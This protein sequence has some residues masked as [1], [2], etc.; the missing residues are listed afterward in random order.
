[1]EKG[2]QHYRNKGKLRV[3]KQG[4]CSTLQ[5]QTYSLT[6]VFFFLCQVFLVWALA[7]SGEITQLS[8]E[9]SFLDFKL[10]QFLSCH[11]FRVW[12]DCRI[13]VYMTP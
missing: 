10:T 13:P 8:L 9:M 12:A 4:S 3:P 1:M 2:V 5:T 6:H 11:T 7:S